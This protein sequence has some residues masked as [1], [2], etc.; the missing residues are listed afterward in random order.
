MTEMMRRIALVVAAVVLLPSA[1]ASAHPSPRVSLVDRSPATV[2]GTSF[3]PAERVA[4]MLSVGDVTLKKTV[5]AR[6]TGAFVARWRRSV[7]TGCVAVGIV[8]H[9]SMGSRAVY[10]LSPPECPRLSRDIAPR[11]ADPLL[12]V[13]HARAW[14]GEWSTAFSSGCRRSFASVSSTRRT[15]AAKA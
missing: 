15:P 11:I 8:A 7:P 10:R 2:R 13:Y 6:A 1:A 9:G 12:A 3:A 14:P 5:V 4:V